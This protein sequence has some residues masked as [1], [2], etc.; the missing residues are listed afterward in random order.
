MAATK[1]WI[2]EY[3]VPSFNS[4]ITS[5][6]PLF[7]KVF[8]FNYLYMDYLLTLRRK[9]GSFFASSLALAHSSGQQLGELVSTFR[10]LMHMFLL[11]CI[12]HC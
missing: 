12:I 11:M 7:R 8:V 4:I 1:E 3:V 5:Q 10:M 2:A 9:S 6:S